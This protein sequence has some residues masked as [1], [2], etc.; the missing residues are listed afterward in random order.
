MTCSSTILVHGWLNK[1]PNCTQNLKSSMTK[2]SLRFV[3]MCK[4]TQKNSHLRTLA[5]TYKNAILEIIM[6]KELNEILEKRGPRYEKKKFDVTTIFPDW[7]N[8]LRK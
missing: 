3:N 4:I 1:D 8:Y 5:S 7:E 6:P 2:L